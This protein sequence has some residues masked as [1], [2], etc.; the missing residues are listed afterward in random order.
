MLFAIHDITR[1]ELYFTDHRDNA[2]R[3]FIRHKA[4][5]PAHTVQMWEAD[6]DTG[7]AEMLAELPDLSS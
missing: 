1:D 2:W 5:H 4:K 6:V 7:H 3:F